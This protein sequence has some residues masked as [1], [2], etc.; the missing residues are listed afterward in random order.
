[1]YTA[2]KILT[3]A[4][5]IGLITELARRF[6]LYGGILA[7]LPLVSLLSLVWLTVQ[8]QSS[9]Q[10]QQFIWGVII[11]LPA[12]IV[13]LVGVFIALKYQ[14][15]LIAAIAIGIMCWLVCLSLQKGIE[16]LITVR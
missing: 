16:L 14:L 2:V 7:A 8:G 4:L 11:G 5:I 15:P 9:A 3:S 6:P 10:L 13:M 12:T 1:M